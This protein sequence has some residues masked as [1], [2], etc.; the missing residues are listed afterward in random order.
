MRCNAECCRY[1]TVD[2]DTPK[3]DEDWDEIKW[4]LMHDKI[5]VYQ[6]LDRE[7]V[8]EFLTK[9]KHLKDNKCS[10]YDKRPEVCKDHGVDECETNPGDFSKVLFKKPEDVDEYLKKI[11]KKVKKRK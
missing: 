11:K 6:N 3:D 2:I 8:V 10:I 1:I 4:M 7:W 9:C 5:M